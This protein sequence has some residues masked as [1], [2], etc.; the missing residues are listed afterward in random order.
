[1]GKL[2]DGSRHGHAGKHLPGEH[3]PRNLHSA[4]G[5]PGSGQQTPGHHIR[6]FPIKA[7]RHRGG[8]QRFFQAYGPHN[9]RVRAVRIP[10]RLV[11][12]FH[13]AF[14]FLPHPGFATVA[15]AHGHRLPHGKP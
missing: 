9:H 7:L 5:K 3:F 4:H 2:L 14:P 12:A 1:M 8:R 11:D 10:A 13:R 15:P 6:R